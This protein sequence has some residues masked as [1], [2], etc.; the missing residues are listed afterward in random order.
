[1]VKRLDEIAQIEN[2][3]KATVM[4]KLIMGYTPVPAVIVPGEFRHIAPGEIQRLNKIKPYSITVSVSWN[5]S[6]GMPYKIWKS[7]KQGLI[8]Q[9]EFTRQYIER[10]M[11]PDAQVEIERLKKLRET[12]DVYVTSFES[13]DGR[14][15]RKIFVDFVNGKIVWK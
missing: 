7:W 6:I 3:P 8:T 13:D 5:K 14:S 12:N 11:L 9:E 1:V 4:E 10:L 2:L 15:M